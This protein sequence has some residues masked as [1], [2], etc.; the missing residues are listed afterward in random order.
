M[1]PARTSAA[2]PARRPWLGLVLAVAAGVLLPLASVAVGLALAGAGPWRRLADAGVPEMALTTVVLLVLTAAGTLVLGAGLAWLVTAYRFPGRDA[3]A[4]L[5]VLPTAV[6][7]YILGLVYAA[8]LSYS[9][10]VQSATRALFGDDAWFPPVRS[11]PVAA[12]VLA[13]TLYPYVYLLAR[14]ALR[15]QAATAYAAARTLGLGPVTAARR[16]VLP[17]TRPALAAGLLLVAVETLS[18]F[19]T[20][21]YFSVDT[22]S[23]GIYRVWR[24]QFD[25]PAATALA[26]LVLLLA[27]AALALERRLRGRARFAQAVRDTRPLVATPLRGAR[28]WAATGVCSAVLAVAVG[29][30]VAQLVLWSSTA[31]LRGAGGGFDTA[32]LTAAAN[33]V[34]LAA[35][36]AAVVLVVAVLLVNAVRLDPSRPV[37]AAAHASLVGYAVPGPVLAI[38]ALLTFAAGREVLDALGLPGGGALVTGTVAGLVLAYT[39]RFLALGFSSV[40]AGLQHVPPSVTTAALTLGAR[41]RRVLARVH[42]PLARSGLGV[43]AVLVAVDALKELPIVLLLRPFGF[44]TLAVRVWQLAADSRWE[45]A[46]LPALTIVAVAMVP[47]ALLFRRERGTVLEGGAGPEGRVEPG[48]P[49]PAHPD[50]GPDARGATSARRGIAVPEGRRP[51]PGRRTEPA[52]G[53]PVVPV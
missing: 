6:P 15:E 24:G 10:P 25:R 38:A 8:L 47:V 49:D 31:P 9:G 53:E 17:L 52:H 2:T 27:L 33:S 13:L 48:H 41:P 20:V 16:V 29:I 35:Q 40:D 43:A 44:D 23:V 22:L 3:L 7:A 12:A 26:L 39:V 50:P 32:F 45:S 46:G 36:T 19:A 30:P 14:A 28:A 1:S 4:W 42:L 21:Q 34:L 18:D 5:L 51:S 37:R 11:V